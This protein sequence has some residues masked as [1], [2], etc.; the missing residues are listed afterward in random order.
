MIVSV[1]VGSTVMVALLLK[2]KNSVETV[3]F[4]VMSPVTANDTGVVYVRIV[5]S[6]GF[7]VKLYRALLPVIVPANMV[8]PASGFM[9]TVEEPAVNVPLAVNSVA[10][11]DDNVIVPVVILVASSL[12]PVAIFILPAAMLQSVAT[13]RITRVDVALVVRSIVIDFVAGKV[14]LPAIFTVSKLAVVPGLISRLPLIVIAPP[15]VYVRAEVAF[16]L[17]VRLP[18][19][20][21][22]DTVVAASDRKITVEAA[23]NV[24]VVNVGMA[25]A[26]VCVAPLSHV[27]VVAAVVPPTQNV[28]P[29]SIC[30][31]PFVPAVIVRPS[32]LNMQVETVM[33]LLL[34]LSVVRLAPRL[35]TVDAPAL[36]VTL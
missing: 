14:M 25:M 4:M 10:V 36:T 6:A 33:P 3:G 7:I 26:D 28:A 2:V 17:R 19:V 8:T 16:G 22:L 35:M 9:I 23:L 27:V 31:V 24:Y 30:K 5:V 34:L 11:V 20:G 15:N 1:L 21:V 13:G 29:E 12:P 18:Y 32:I